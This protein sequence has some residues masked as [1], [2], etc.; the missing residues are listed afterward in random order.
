VPAG[1]LQAFAVDPAL[2]G[3]VAHITSY[4]EDIP[5]GEERIERVLPDGAVHLIFHF[6]DE[7][8]GRASAAA[9]GPST[10]PVVLRFRHRIEGLSVALRP[11][12]V[13]ALLGV[14]AGEI[15]GRVVRLDELWGAE[16]ASLLAR[17]HEAPDDAARCHLLQRAL[18]ER[19]RDTAAGPAPIAQAARL[20]AHA[21]GQ[22]PLREVADALGIGERRLQQLFHVEVGLSP[23]S[24]SRLARLHACLR[25]LR[26]HA[27]P[28]WAEVAVDAGFY[29]QSHLANE[30]RALCGLSPSVFLA[31]SGS[32]KT[33]G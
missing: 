4:R 6:G 9:A 30:F 23:R 13:A 22:R 31:V 14:P 28:R 3:H 32:S 17:M 2:A 33:G 12:A 25:A 16:G 26:Q 19:V 20:I 27:A 11:G 29:D 7:A 18:Q 21:G 10:A 1:T 24:W 5:D 15:A 8:G